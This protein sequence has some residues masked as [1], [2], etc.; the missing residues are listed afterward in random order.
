MCPPDYMYLNGR[1]FRN[2]GMVH[3]HDI[4]LDNSLHQPVGGEKKITSTHS[5]KIFYKLW[6]VFLI[7][8]LSKSELGG[9]NLNL[10]ETICEKATEGIILNG[11]M[12]N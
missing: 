4:S 1:Y 9:N 3:H 7:K 10:K 5:K 6:Q 2:V 8:Y 12:L 11:E